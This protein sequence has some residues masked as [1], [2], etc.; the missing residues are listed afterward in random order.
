MRST[1]N[2][3]RRRPN[4]SLVPV[5][6][7]S[8]AKIPTSVSILSRAPVPGPTWCRESHRRRSAA[9]NNP[10]APRRRRILAL[11]LCIVATHG[12]LQFRKL[13]H[14]GGHQVRLAELRRAPDSFTRADA[15]AHPLRERFDAR[16]FVRV[17]AELGLVSDAGQFRG[18]AL[19]RGRAV[20]IPEEGRIAQAWP[21]HA[22]VALAHLGGILAL[23]V[24]HR[25]E[26]A[27]QPAVG[28][29]TG[30]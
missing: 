9:D 13:A 19:E 4:G 16:G 25:D 20:L 28:A 18:V 30:K 5:G 15:A 6:R 3:A 27:G 22:F 11:R 21:H 7:C 23:D 24:A 2:A 10:R 14:H 8:I 29:S 12:A 26:A 17:A 1:P